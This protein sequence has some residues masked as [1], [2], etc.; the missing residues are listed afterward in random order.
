MDKASHLVRQPVDR[1]GRWRWRFLRV[2]T[3]GSRFRGNFVE[4]VGI[5]RGKCHLAGVQIVN[6]GFKAGAGQPG[7]SVDELQ[8]LHT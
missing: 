1:F 8:A 2:P 5:E 3:P 6:H 7:V 4:W